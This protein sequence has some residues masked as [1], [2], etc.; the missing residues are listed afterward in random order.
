M[1]LFLLKHLE[2]DFELFRGGGQIGLQLATQDGVHLL[3]HGVHGALL[4]QSVAIFAL[5]VHGKSGAFQRLDFLEPLLDG[6]EGLLL[7]V[8][9]PFAVVVAHRHH[10]SM[11]TTN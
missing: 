3:Q 10:M 5:L 7:Q 11:Y 1:L 8:V 2:D 9:L 4:Q 6:G